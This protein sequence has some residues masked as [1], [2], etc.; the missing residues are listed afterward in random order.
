M[1]KKKSPYKK[2]LLESSENCIG[3]NR[4]KNIY[5]CHTG[6]ADE[7]IPETERI[8][9][10][11]QEEKSMKNQKLRPKKVTAFVLALAMLS[12]SCSSRKNEEGSLSFNI[13]V[14]ASKIVNP[15]IQIAE[16]KG[17]FSEYNFKPK[18][19][20]LEMIGTPEALIAGKLDASYAQVIPPVSYGAQGAS[21]K[22]FAG[23]LSGGM[24]TICRKEDAEKLRNLENWKG[25]KIGVIHLSTAEMV[26]KASLGKN[27]GYDI[28]NDLSYQLIDGYPAI[29]TA[30]AKGNIDIGFISSEYLEAAVSLGLERLFPLTRLEKDYVCCR[31]YAYAPTFEENRP[32]FKAYL[33]GQIRAY[34]D[35]SLF[36]DES[37][38][39]LARLTGEDVDYIARYIYDRE[40]NGDRSY[41]PD[42]NY[43]GVLSIYEILTGWKYIEAN[44]PLESFFDIGLYAESLKEVIEEFPD[45]VFYRNMWDYF[46]KNNDRHPSFN[47]KPL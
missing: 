41:N 5:I 2:I 7:V 25:K 40:S 10:K 12:V 3:K 16:E 19:T 17:Y 44:A 36:P 4:K 24:E 47:Y 22:I 38:G 15:L 26:S 46:L 14:T 43:N 28:K 31:Q 30:V 33:K 27:Y 11:T 32:A 8:I 18:Y 34:R 1:A 45:E 13:A 23:T 9:S 35:Y 20:T 21:V 42:P 6:C 37:I 29:T 39:S